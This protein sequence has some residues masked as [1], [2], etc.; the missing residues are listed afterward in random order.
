MRWEGAQSPAPPFEKVANPQEQLGRRYWTV[1][2]RG[3]GEG[4]G[5]SETRVGRHVTARRRL[6]FR[7][8]LLP[9]GVFGTLFRRLAGDH[10]GDT[11]A[12]HLVHAQQV[13]VEA[14]LV[15]DLGDAAQVA[16]DEAA[17]GVEVLALELR[18]QGLVNDPYRDAAVYRVGAVRELADRR[19]FFVEL[20]PDLADYL[21]DD[22]LQGEE[23][24]EG[25]PL[26]YDYRHL[27]FVAL[28]LLE[29]PVYWTVLG[30]DENLAGEVAG[31]Q[32]GVEA[33]L[34][35]DGAQHVLDVHGADD[36]IGRVVLVDRVAGIVTRRRDRDKLLQVHLRRERDD[37]GAGDHDPAR[38]LVVELE[39]RADHLLL[40]S[41]EH[42]SPGRLPDQGPDLA[43]RVRVVALGGR[44]VSQE[45]GDGV[46]RP[47]EHH[48]AGQQQ[49][50]EEP[51]ERRH[52]ERGPLG[53]LDGYGLGC[54]LPEDHVQEG[55]DPEG[56]GQ[57]DG[58]EQ[59]LR[60][61]ER[62]EQRLDHGRD[63]R[64]AEPAQP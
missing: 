15:P 47:V 41:L 43:L 45:P 16:K 33:A 54:E 29:D 64:L 22:V 51:H 28:E 46:G 27:E 14:D 5:R 61:P 2:R 37:I 9:L 48:D 7:G 32:V 17:D 58:V 30:N 53:A 19:F 44:R 11:G 50:V 24:L 38:N 10:L 31:R 40:V 55:D 35:L 3:A 52:E 12:V 59:I 39:D 1:L 6:P 4:A 62:A 20:V 60:H 56:Y 13:A 63:R 36:P 18:T 26:V 34:R 8:V 49:I 21:F 23:P 25:A 42:A 57:R